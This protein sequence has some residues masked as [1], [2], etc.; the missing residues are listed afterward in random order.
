MDLPRGVIGLSG[1]FLI[2][3]TYFFLLQ[4]SMQTVVLYPSY[5]QL[6]LRLIIFMN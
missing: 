1:Y 2:I 4:P 5:I 6:K 3:L